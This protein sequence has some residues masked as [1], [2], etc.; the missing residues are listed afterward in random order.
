[1]TTTPKQAEQAEQVDPMTDSE[2]VDPSWNALAYAASSPGEGSPKPKHRALAAELATREAADPH[3]IPMIDDLV[4][5]FGVDVAGEGDKAHPLPTLEA[6]RA[7]LRHYRLRPRRNLMSHT[8][9]VWWQGAPHKKGPAWVSSVA[10]RE[11]YARVGVREFLPELANEDAYHPVGEWIQSRA[12][13]G[14]DRLPELLAT[15]TP[16]PV[17]LAATYIQRWMRGAA[18]LACLPEPTTPG[19][20][21]GC[22][23][24]GVLTLK[25]PQGRRKT[26]WIA[27]LSPR[28]EWTHRE[29]QAT[30]L[31]NKDVQ[32]KITNRWIVELAEVEKAIRRNDSESLKS[33][34]TTAADERRNP[35]AERAEVHQRR[36]IY[37][38]TTNADTFLVDPSGNRRWWVIDVDMCDPGALIQR[39]PE[40]RQ[41]VWAQAWAEW[42]REGQFSH[43]LTPA[44]LETL[45]VWNEAH[46]E[47]TAEELAVLDAF[48]VDAPEAERVM[49]YSATEVCE[50]LD[51]DIQRTATV[52]NMGYALA[53]YFGQVK[54]QGRT[55]Y[56]MPRMKVVAPKDNGGGGWT[57]R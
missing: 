48:A 7:L 49:R 31:G 40:W 36:T 46:R 25:G 9:E 57:P 1:M 47:K 14:R 17:G 3:R 34:I 21:L 4:D 51:L 54:A 6:L 10:A 16:T 44:E 15:L 42:N 38:G 19:G 39:G 2:Q 11:R 56:K 26:S 20:E 8:D 27:A 30:D 33:W 32:A 52:R 37:A 35:Y 55:V 5:V 12:W 53:R 24:Q 18:A 23:M 50:L 43:T 45:A 29:V 13:D 28:V 41:Q 22:I